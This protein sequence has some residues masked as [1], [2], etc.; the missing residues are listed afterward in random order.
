MH[1][2][3][4]WLEMVEVFTFSNLGKIV[5]VSKKE[6]QY[7]E[8]LAGISTD[9]S[10]LKQLIGVPKQHVLDWDCPGDKD[11]FALLYWCKSAGQHAQG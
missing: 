1:F 4:R 10:L 3:Q 8:F 11:Q 2:D 6:G 5:M 9:T 7:S